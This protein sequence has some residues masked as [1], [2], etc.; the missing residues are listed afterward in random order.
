MLKGTSG[1]STAIVV[2]GLRA[3]KLLHAAAKQSAIGDGKRRPAFSCLYHFRI[4]G[5]DC[6][7][8]PKSMDAWRA[9]KGLA[10]RSAPELRRAAR[11][12]AQSDPDL[13]GRA[14]RR[15]HD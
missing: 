8:T 12:S 3:I 9:C 15:P 6:L 1:F 10:P 4:F 7:R 2:S 14:G 13:D 5:I 11:L